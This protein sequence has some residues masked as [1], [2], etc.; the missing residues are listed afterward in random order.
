MVLVNRGFVPSERKE[1]STR[2]RG[3]VK[4]EASVVGLLRMSEPKGGFLRSN[5]PAQDRWFSRDVD[6]IGRAR[7]LGH[8]APYFID[9]D[10]A[11]NAGGWP[12]GGMTVV[13][14]PNNHLVYS[15]T[16]FALAMLSLTGLL[17]VLR[18]RR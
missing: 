1:Q 13:A 17:L 10:A 12:R 4:G 11:F 8:A 14:F 15:I 3:L 18:T 5:Q 7:G 9:A 2:R 16:W 6:A